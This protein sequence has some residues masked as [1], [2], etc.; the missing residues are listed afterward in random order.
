VVTPFKGKGKPEWQ[1]A[2]NRL[3]A[4]LRG[5]GERMFAQL[6]KWSIFDQVRCDPHRVTELAKAVQVL[7]AYEAPRMT[8][9]GSACFAR[10][11]VLHRRLQSDRRASVTSAA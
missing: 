4:R 3:H 1:K 5:P 10:V 7:N 8:G 2:D 6:K 9:N 11:V